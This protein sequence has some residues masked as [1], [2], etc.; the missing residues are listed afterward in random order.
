LK[1]NSDKK[2]KIIIVAGGSGGHIFP[3]IAVIDEL[4]KSSYEILMITDK[5]GLSF[6]NLFPDITI[7]VVKSD[8]PFGKNKLKKII[9][10]FKII[11]GFFQSVWILLNFSPKLIIGFGG[12][13]SFPP[14]IIAYLL[15]IPIIIHEQNLVMGR[16]NLFLAN[17][18]RKIAVSHKDTKN[19]PFKYINKVSF[20]GNPIRKE[21]CKLRSISPPSYEYKNFFNILVFGG[22]Q[23][24]SIFSDLIPQSLSLL[25][26]S[27]RLNINIV[28]QAV[29][30]DLV[31]LKETYNNL[32]ISA[33]VETFFEN[34]P[35]HISEADMIISR[36]GATSI[37]E[38]RIIGKPSILIPLSHSIDNDQ[39][40]NAKKMECDGASFLI[41]EKDLNGKFLSDKIN[42]FYE[43]REVLTK[44]SLAAYKT[45]NVNAAKNIANLI[46][47]YY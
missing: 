37:D 25:K 34:L 28:Q 42:Y 26:K 24:A 33:K 2:K 22:S 3:A 8:T 15:R 46:L 12:Y 40:I 1:D 16:A 29:K 11:L 14:I 27:L 20:T 4:I 30:E 21:I 5:R 45:G 17:L 47:T 7:R 41:E 6:K 19:F 23:G 13:P 43:N 18:A 38:F 31:S 44:M 10:L 36:A 32:S 35:V 39:Y 9:F